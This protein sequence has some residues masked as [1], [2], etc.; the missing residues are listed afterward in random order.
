M[1]PVGSLEKCQRAFH[2][3]FPVG[4]FTSCDRLWVTACEWKW[5]RE[6]WGA[7]ICLCTVTFFLFLVAIVFTLSMV[8]TFIEAAAEQQE[9]NTEGNTGRE[10]VMCIHDYGNMQ[11][12]A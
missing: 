10:G 8:N 9:L 1:R 6:E 11:C 2:H 3:C 5:D 7:G 4:A 12:D